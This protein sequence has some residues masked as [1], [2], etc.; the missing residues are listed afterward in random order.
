MSIYCVF[1]CDYFVVFIS[2]HFIVSLC[3]F[4]IVASLLRANMIS[5][6]SKSLSIQ[7]TNVIEPLNI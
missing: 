7:M 2:T 3:I 6:Y 5:M 4:I 1:L